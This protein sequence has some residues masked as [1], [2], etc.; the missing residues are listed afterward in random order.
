MMDSYKIADYLEETYPDQPSLFY[1][2][3]KGPVDPASPQAKM[4]KAYLTLFAAG[5]H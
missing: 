1:P 5:E 3:V 2:G 4:A